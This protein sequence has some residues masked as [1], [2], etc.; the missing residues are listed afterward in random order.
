ML[1]NEMLYCLIAFILGWLISRHIGNGFS[2]GAWNCQPSCPDDHSICV[3]N[4]DFCN[5]PQDDGH[6]TCGFGGDGWN[7]CCKKEDIQQCIKSLPT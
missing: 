5:N 4:E 7:S 6:G 2:V 1:D 3:H